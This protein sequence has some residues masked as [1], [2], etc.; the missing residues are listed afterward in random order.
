MGAEAVEF[1]FVVAEKWMRPCDGFARS[2]FAGED[3]PDFFKRFCDAVFQVLWFGECAENEH[4]LLDSYRSLV[5]RCFDLA[6]PLQKVIV[7]IN[8]QHEMPEWI[9]LQEGDVD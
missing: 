9:L 2:A 7:E 4:S 8:E 6:L 1:G 5:A 3:C